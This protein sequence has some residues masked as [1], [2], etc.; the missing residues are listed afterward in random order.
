MESQRASLP[1][2]EKLG[3]PMMRAQQILEKAIVEDPAAAGPRVELGSLLRYRGQRDGAVRELR[4]AKAR[5]H[6]V[7][8]HLV[9]DVTVAL[10]EVEELPAGALEI[11][12]P[13]TDDVRALFPAAYVAMK[14]DDFVLAKR[15]L[16]R[17]KAVLPADTFLY[18][19]NDP[20]FRKFAYREDLKPYFGD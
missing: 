20:A 4:A 2:N 11:S 10:I 16:D 7:D 17:C 1:A 15:L 19:V 13:A 6:P 9:I 3:D 18:L 5:L 14:K 8:S 12:D